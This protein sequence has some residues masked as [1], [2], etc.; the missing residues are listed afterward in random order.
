MVKLWTLAASEE[1]AKLAR[2]GGNVTGLL[3]YEQGVTGI[4][5]AMLKEMAPHVVRTALLAN[6]KTTPY[7]YFLRS[8]EAVAQALA[9]ELVCRPVED[10]SRLER[11]IAGFAGRPNGGLIVLPPTR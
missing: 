2:P 7:E 1:I 10:P 3:L 11:V 5:A 8:A 6:P 4:W 9:L